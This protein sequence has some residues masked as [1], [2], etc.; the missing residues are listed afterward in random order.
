MMVYLDEI[1]P[2]LV[3][4]VFLM[5]TGFIGNLHVLFVY[6]FRLKPSNHGIYIRFLSVQD[7]IACVLLIP[8]QIYIFS[9]LWTYGNEFTC[10]IYSF[11]SSLIHT[12]T[13]STLLLIATDRYRKICCPLGWQ[14]KRRIAKLLCIIVLIFG[15]FIS[16]PFLVLIEPKTRE[17]NN[18]TTTR[19]GD[20][21]MKY[22]QYYL[23]TMATIC[24]GLLCI[25]ICLYVLI[26]KSAPKYYLRVNIKDT[27]K[28]TQGTNKSSEAQEEYASREIM[29]PPGED[30]MQ[31]SDYRKPQDNFN[32]DPNAKEQQS[33]NCN[34]RQTCTENCN[35][36]SKRSNR[37]KK[38]ITLF[39]LITVLYFISYIPF[40][41]GRIFRSHELLTPSLTTG[42]V[43][44]VLQLSIFI[45]SAANC[46]IYSCFDTRFRNEIGLMYK[47]LRYKFKH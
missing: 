9:N 44:T 28:N 27:E 11:G 5:V 13:A 40:L 1:K 47:T 18:V 12:A 17:L 30:I 26:F 22:E 42:I 23:I 32:F 43:Y 33:T 29:T 24:V 10:R 7:T 39:I 36:D 38:M 31:P 2:A 3:L 14:I 16:L 21:S 20:R 19:C 46:F 6:T 15:C 37:A 35:V 25:L 8:T 4:P 41:A 45:N 34:T